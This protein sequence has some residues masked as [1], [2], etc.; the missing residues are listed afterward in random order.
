MLQSGKLSL[1]EEEGWKNRLLR[2][3]ISPVFHPLYA[4]GLLMFLPVFLSVCSSR[5]TVFLFLSICSSSVFRRFL[6]RRITTL[7]YPFLLQFRCECTF[8]IQ[9]CILFE[10]RIGEWTSTLQRIAE[11][12]HIG[13]LEKT[14][15]CDETRTYHLSF[16]GDE[17][18]CILTESVSLRWETGNLE[19]PYKD[20]FTEN[21]YH[22]LFV[23]RAVVEFERNFNTR[24]QEHSTAL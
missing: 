8:V 5:L 16:R 6:R 7:N 9:S 20:I 1:L 21:A 11:M 22:F 23:R 19:L 4:P 12:E 3:A 14:G 17:E 13:A 15:T 10:T 2:E 24:I 18:K